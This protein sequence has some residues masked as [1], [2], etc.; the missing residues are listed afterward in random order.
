MKSRFIS[1][2]MAIV[3]SVSIGQCFLI[4]KRVNV[5]ADYVKNMQ[6]TR[7][8]TKQMASPVKPTDRDSAWQGSYVIFGGWLGGSLTFRVLDP[9]TT[10]FGESTILL[11]CDTIIDTEPFGI[12][13]YDDYEDIRERL[14]EHFLNVAFYSAEEDAIANSYKDDYDYSAYPYLTY[15]GCQSQPLNGDKLFLLDAAEVH[16][17]DYGYYNDSGFKDWDTS[18]FKSYSVWNHAKTFYGN[19]GFQYYWLRSDFIEH[20]G[21]ALQINDEGQIACDNVES[22][23]GI[24]P[25]LNIKQS[26]ILFSTALSGDY[27]ALGTKYRLTIIDKRLNQRIQKEKSTK[28]WTLIDNVISVPY[29]IDTS[30]AYYSKDIID[31]SILITD[32]EYTDPNANILF[33]EYSDWFQST[34]DGTVANFPLSDD[35][36]LD[37]SKWGKD[38]HVYFVAEVNQSDAF[39]S[40]EP[41]E[42]VANKPVISKA[43]PSDNGVLVKW[44]KVYGYSS[45]NVYRSNSLNGTYTYLSSVTGGTTK[46][47]D[48]TATG[49]K[50]YYYKV[51]PYLKISSGSYA[52]LA[53]TY[54]GFWSDA[55]KVT[56]LADTKLTAEPKSGVTM[57]LSWTAVS[58]AQSYE[59]YRSTSASGPYTYVKAT[60]GTSTSDTSLKAGTRYYYM[61]RAKKT[62]NGEAQYS[63][64]AAAVAVA[65]ATPTLESA[66][67]KSGKGVTLNW[68]KASGADRYNVYKYNASTGKYDYVASVLGGT[69]TY[70][71]A[72][73]KK[74]DYYKVRAYKRVDGVVYYGGWSNAKAG[75]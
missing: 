39:F 7:L 6:N 30:V 61:V 58:G 21:L 2:A 13:E 33:Y 24:A 55:M 36:N 66:A 43:E 70:T 65:L 40:S 47:V 12:S 52:F 20:E 26:S 68:T 16:N 25:A 17:P 74:G 69:L 9:Y 60:T 28:D 51:R 34:S 45:Y 67:F 35:L 54:Y 56:V 4:G 14:N 42:L 71:D 1:A 44:N 37:Q 11:D 59:I 8:G 46:Y 64:Y 29:K 41:I 63:K 15:W 57:K 62:V 23:G 72:N 27:G 32:K 19:S 53:G 18:S 75:K 3:M 38:Y 49:G 50:T 5:S 10:D 31:Y 48:K 22:D 73:G